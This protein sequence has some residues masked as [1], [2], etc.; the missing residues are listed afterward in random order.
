MHDQGP[1]TRSYRS[2]TT[3]G[4]LDEINKNFSYVNSQDLA[5]VEGHE[6]Y[7]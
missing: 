2:D 7:H 4:G 3:I 1:N 6:D 5:K